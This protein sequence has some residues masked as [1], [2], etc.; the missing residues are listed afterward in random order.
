M[1]L[2]SINGV[3]WTRFYQSATV[4][5]CATIVYAGCSGGGGGGGS[6]PTGLDM[7]GDFIVDATQIFASGGIIGDENFPGQEKNTYERYINV[8]GDIDWFRVSLVGG[9]LYGL[10]LAFLPTEFNGSIGDRT[11]IYS[12]FDSS[13]TISIPSTSQFGYPGGVIDS[14]EIRDVFIAPYTGNYYFRFRGR[15]AQ[16]VAQYRFRVSSSRLGFAVPRGL[17]STGDNKFGGVVRNRRSF[18][19]I[20]DGDENLRYQGPNSPNT[21]QGFPLEEIVGT[22]DVP[23]L[24]ITA[25]TDGLLPPTYT[26]SFVADNDLSGTVSEVTFFDANGDLEE[27]PETPVAHLHVGIPSGDFN[28]DVDDIFWNY[29]GGIGQIGPLDNFRLDRNSQVSADAH[30]VIAD[31]TDGFTLDESIIHLIVAQPFYI[32]LHMTNQIE[33]YNIPIVSSHPHGGLHF[34]NSAFLLNGFDTVPATGSTKTLEVVYDD[35]QQTFAIQYDVQPEV[36]IA[37]ADIHVHAGRPGEVNPEILLDLGQVPNL[38]SRPV[39]EP[40]ASLQGFVPGVENIIKRL[41]NEE[42]AILLDASYTTGWYIDV[43]TSPFFLNPSTPEIRA[44]AVFSDNLEIAS[45]RIDFPPPPVGDT[46]GVRNGVVNI[47]APAKGTVSFASADL[48]FGSVH[49]FLNGTSLGELSDVAN[50]DEVVCGVDTS[51]TVSGEISPGTYYYRAFAEGV[52]WDGHVTVDKESCS[53][54]ALSADTAQFLTN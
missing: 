37:G 8:P 54:I 44:D 15:F 28:D 30:P 43:H 47:V 23:Y 1:F 36:G 13:G 20:V 24:G 46:N 42:A 51:A 26:A 22:L 45:S 9:N 38:Q 40:D 10:Q 6:D 25:I 3:R 11:Y 27:S 41:T 4:L 21:P 29:D 2:A 33:L 34:F 12:I 17:P 32:D 19:Q 7:D 52:M 31:V 14:G 49:V 48:D 35:T 53:T 50:G 18:I 5:I 16:S 39:Y